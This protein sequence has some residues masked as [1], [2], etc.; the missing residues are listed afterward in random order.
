LS[1]LNN[2]HLGLA[3]FLQVSSILAHSNL[4][5]CPVLQLRTSLSSAICVNTGTQMHLVL[6]VFCSRLQPVTFSVHRHS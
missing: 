6:T 1:Y 4:S 5:N 3:E 2:T